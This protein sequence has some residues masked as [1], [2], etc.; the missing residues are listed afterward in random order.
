MINIRI[1][2]HVLGFASLAIGL[3][4]PVQAGATAS[5]SAPRPK[6]PIKHVITLMQENHSFDNY[7]G[8][9]PGANGIPEGTCLP[10]DPTDR[11][12]TTCI[13]S[14]HLGNRAV[15]DLNH[16]VSTYLHQYHNGRMDGFVY[17][18]RLNGKDGTLTMGYY[19]DSDLPFYWNIAADYVL[20]DNFFSS[21]GGGSVKNH[22]FWLT[23]T[24]GNKLDAIPKDGWGD[25][26]TIF[27]RL[28]ERGV[29]W[30]F[31]VQNYDPKITLWNRIRGDRGAQ[32]VWVPLL[33]YKRYI[34]NPKL[35]SHIV[36]LEEYFKDLENGTLPAVSYIVPSGASEHPPGSIRAG[37]RFV[38]TL[39]NG[40]MESDSWNDSVFLWTY[41]DWGGWYDHVKPPQ[42]DEHGYGFRV[43]ALLVSAYARKGH[44]DHTL[45]DFTSMMKFIE[46]NWDLKPLAER[47]AKANSFVSALDFSQPPRVPRIISAE[48]NV[49]TIVEPRRSIIYIAYITIYFLA[50]FIIGWVAIST[51]GRLKQAP[52]TPPAL[53]E[54]IV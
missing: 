43:P 17:A 15:E 53:D 48:R 22:M 47:D 28:E 38:K 34:D 8:T 27:D 13:K 33:A 32:V 31:Y 50:A 26:P 37:Q 49:A 9:Y 51:G 35:F 1:F 30:K 19:D 5:Q 18:Y 23:G 39:L 16:N 10:V 14:F 3:T 42:V 25:L 40:L 2:L 29:S 36:N 46:E 45:L 6:T 21:A 44:V 41:D 11:K 24:A 54:E 12:N 20:F 7:F 4:L 52:R